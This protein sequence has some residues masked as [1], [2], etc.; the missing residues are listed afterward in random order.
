MKR[1]L[2]ASTLVILMWFSLAVPGRAATTDA[3]AQLSSEIG[4]AGETVVL[5]VS[6]SGNLGLS[7]YR[8]SVITGTD[9]ISVDAIEAGEWSQGGT[10]LANLEKGEALWFAASNK[11]DDG[12]LFRITLRLED[13]MMNGDYPIGLLCHEEDIVDE[14]GAVV[15]IVA[16]G[17]ILT[18][19]GGAEAPPPSRP[20]GGRPSGAPSAPEVPEAHANFSDLPA[21]HWA[22]AYVDRL[23]QAGTVQGVGDG[24]FAPDNIVTR[25]EFVTMLHRALGSPQAIGASSFTDVAPSLWYASAVAWAAE[26]G[27][28]KGTSETTFSPNAPITREQLATILHRLLALKNVHFST[29]AVTFADQ[30]EISGYAVEAVGAIRA[31]DIIEGYPDGRFGPKDNA[32]RAAAAK[33]LCGSLDTLK[34]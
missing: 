30:G 8:F 12:E 27:V 22:Y 29:A 31:L 4:R 5:S 21:D 17:G 15:S 3:T 7:G 6:L 9:A 18:I 32:T 33:M 10:F 24:R 16:Q 11:S 28:I 1:R 13:G 25:A 14:N 2:L 26:S 19:T 34:Q 20:S 23:W